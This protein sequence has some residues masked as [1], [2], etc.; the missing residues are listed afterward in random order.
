MAADN[1]ANKVESKAKNIAREGILK[2]VGVAAI[3]SG[4]MSTIDDSSDNV[5]ALASD[6]VS[7]GINQGRR[8]VFDANAA[9]IQGYTRSEVM[10]D[11]TCGDCMDIDNMSVSADDPFAQLD[12]IHTNCRGIWIPILNDDPAIAD[13]F[14]VPAK[15]SNRFDTNPN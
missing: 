9:D 6:A 13:D 15:I 1:F 14:G 3:I 12:Q 5:D 4:V 11:V 7:E 2:N 8:S 10:D